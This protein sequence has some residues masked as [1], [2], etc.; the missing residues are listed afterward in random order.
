MLETVKNNSNNY[1]N[2]NSKNKKYRNKP[3][4][5]NRK[6]LK[7]A[8]EVFHKKGGE[9]SKLKPLSEEHEKAHAHYRSDVR[10]NSYFFEGN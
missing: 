6:F 4:N 9:I 7:D 5:P 10:F 3:F 8:L 1:N 2:N